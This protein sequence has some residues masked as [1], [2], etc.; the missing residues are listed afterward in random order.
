[1]APVLRPRSG[2]GRI[3]TQVSLNLSFLH[4]G[5]VGNKENWILLG[6]E[7]YPELISGNKPSH[8]HWELED[9]TAWTFI[10]FVFGCPEK[11]KE[12]SMKKNIKNEVLWS[13]ISLTFVSHIQQFEATNDPWHVNHGV[14]WPGP[15]STCTGA[16]PAD[17][18]GAVPSGLPACSVLIP[19][20]Q[21]GGGSRWHIVPLQGF[22]LLPVQWESFEVEYRDR[23]VQCWEFSCIF[24]KWS[25]WHVGTGL[26]G[27]RHSFIRLTEH[28]DTATAQPKKEAKRLSQANL[29]NKQTP[30]PPTFIH[31][32]VCFKHVWQ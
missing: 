23:K 10:T 11:S 26:A 22:S 7:V 2:T 9:P 29:T 17:E 25:A 32:A 24:L 30:P 19:N 15:C 14:H 20:R 3:C 13:S 8:L 28:F 27:F 5:S 16:A 1:M 6:S 21:G 4:T 31:K 12:E 18:G